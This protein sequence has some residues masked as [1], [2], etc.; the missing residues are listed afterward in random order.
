MGKK[1]A[2]K[3]YFK[4]TEAT[5]DLDMST[6][7]KSITLN[8]GLDVVDLTT[9]GDTTGKTKGAGF[10]DWSIELQCAYDSTADGLNDHIDQWLT[11]LADDT[12]EHLAIEVRFSSAAAAETNPKY[13]GD[14]ILE[15]TTPVSGSAGEGGVIALTFQ[16]TG[17]L[18]RAEA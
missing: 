8:H 6:L 15:S 3:A 11:A 17:A 14:A 5:Y 13:T 9:M 4:V 18:V 7:I 2:K 12:I 1:V 16:G 10:L